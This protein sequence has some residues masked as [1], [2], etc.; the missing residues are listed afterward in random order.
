MKDVNLCPNAY[1]CAVCR[2]EYHRGRPEEDTLAE[3][4]YRMDN[5]PGYADKEPPVLVCDDCFKL[6]MAANLH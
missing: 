5:L 2:N 6:V 3:H 1:M 4:Q